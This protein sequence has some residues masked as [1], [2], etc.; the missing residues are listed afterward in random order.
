MP[1]WMRKRS[2]LLYVVVLFVSAAVPA[3][4]QELEQMI[5]VQGFYDNPASTGTPA[6]AGIAANA[7]SLFSGSVSPKETAPHDG[8]GKYYLTQASIGWPAPAT[9]GWIDPNAAFPAN[10]AEQLAYLGYQYLKAIKTLFAGYYQND[11]PTTPASIYLAFDY[12]LTQEG[13]RLV[14]PK[15]EKIILPDG[16]LQDPDLLFD[17][18]QA[19]LAQ[20]TS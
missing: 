7:C 2:Q 5:F 15:G 11:N 3:A 1:R 8:D 13:K 17:E 19:D 10:A 20:Q 6:G 12:V 16:T 14:M 4:A 18:E 9:I